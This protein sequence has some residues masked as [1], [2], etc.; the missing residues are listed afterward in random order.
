MIGNFDRPVFTRLCGYAHKLKYF[1]LKSENSHEH[2]EFN[3][4]Q[5][6][7]KCIYRLINTYLQKFHCI[8]FRSLK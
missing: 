5:V 8:G 2:I 1:A 3:K 4:L 6:M 7:L